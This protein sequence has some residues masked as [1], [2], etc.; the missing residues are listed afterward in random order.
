VTHGRPFPPPVPPP[1]QER[2]LLAH[3]DGLL[4][5][6]NPPPAPTRASRDAAAAAAVE[7]VTAPRM[8]ALL[9]GVADAIA[10]RDLPSWPRRGGGAAALAQGGQPPQEEDEEELE[11]AAGQPQQQAPG[12]GAGG[13]EG[14]AAAAGGGG[15]AG[16]P[17]QDPLEALWRAEEDYSGS[18]DE[19]YDD[20]PLA[21]TLEPAIKRDAK[22]RVLQAGPLEAL[23]PLSKQ[24]CAPWEVGWGGRA[25]GGSL[26]PDTGQAPGACTPMR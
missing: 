23:P 16:A 17:P 22:F 18:G 10:V 9:R 2:L 15:G 13:G 11:G 26:T 21:E 5:L 6:L 4:Y 24:W 14:Y 1:S 25:D 3:Q 19:G 8:Q 7:P 12:P 20:T